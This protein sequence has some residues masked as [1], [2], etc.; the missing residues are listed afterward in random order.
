MLVFNGVQLAGT[1]SAEHGKIPQQRMKKHLLSD[2]VR[3]KMRFR[4]EKLVTEK[5]LIGEMSH[6]D[7]TS[8][9]QDM[10]LRLS[11]EA[12]WKDGVTDC[13]C[14]GLTKSGVS[15]SFLSGSKSDKQS[16]CASFNQECPHLKEEASD[17]N[18]QVMESSIGMLSLGLY[19]SPLFA[20]FT[21]DLCDLEGVQQH[22]TRCEKSDT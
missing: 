3:K 21:E 7:G 11:K 2:E 22:S 9:L 20:C 14:K 1:V 19:C 13:G 17:C 4:A 5:V 16:F 12:K 15:S 10:R 8:L 6:E 18:P